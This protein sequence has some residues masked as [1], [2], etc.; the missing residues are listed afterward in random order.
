[1]FKKLKLLMQ[2]MKKD[3][4]YLFSKTYSGTYSTPLA[5]M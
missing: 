3:I 4:K 5:V 2:S 1:M